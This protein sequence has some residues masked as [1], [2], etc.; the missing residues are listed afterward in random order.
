MS[1]FDISASSVTQLGD[2][3]VVGGDG[4]LLVIPATQPEPERTRR[5]R[6]L[7]RPGI[8]FKR[9]ILPNLEHNNRHFFQKMTPILVQTPPN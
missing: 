9:Q 3:F 6:L 4:L 8:V 1:K 7:A 2:A 5:L